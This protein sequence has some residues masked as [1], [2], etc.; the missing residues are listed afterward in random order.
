MG[1]SAERKNTEQRER[2]RKRVSVTGIVYWCVGMNPDE[3]KWPNENVPR[4]R[5]EGG[6]FNH[7][8]GEN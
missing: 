1:N 4:E 2:K 6:L 3:T 8:L 7:A 5:G